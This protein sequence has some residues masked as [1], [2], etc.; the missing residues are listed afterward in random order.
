MQSANDLESTFLRSWRLLS[1]NWG[2]IVPG[3]VIG[4]VAG[5]VD[6]FLAL[7]GAL[8]GSALIGVGASG[9]GY[10]SVMLAALLVG[11][12]SMLAAI[13]TIAYTTGMAGAA[14]DRGTATFSDGAA[15]F[16]REGGQ[17]L[18]AVV[19]L[20]VIGVVA[21]MLS[22]FTFGLAM[23]AYVIFFI[24]TMAA[25]I[26]GNAP[27]IEGI[28]ESSRLAAK[29][30]VTTLLLVVLIFVISF[31]GG[32]VGRIFDGVPLL[33]H[34]VALVISQIVLSYATLVVVGEYLKLRSTA[35]QTPT[36]S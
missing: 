31:V 34:V 20:F 3:L 24:Y 8:G 29:N 7:T 4:V 5:L 30:F 36:A 6:G 28:V 32:L 35:V 26:V 13:L 14:W 27:A 9:A 19:L 15:A 25:V 18:L 17:T 10:L 33:N 23:L 16:K 12:V 21:A 11:V 2:I 22:I 1:S